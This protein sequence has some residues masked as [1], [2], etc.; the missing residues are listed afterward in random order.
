MENKR[1][2]EEQKIETDTYKKLSQKVKLHVNLEEYNLSHK[3]SNLTEC[4]LSILKYYNY[5]AQNLFFK[6]L[7]K[8]FDSVNKLE[9]LDNGFDIYFRS[10]GEMGKISR[11]FTKYF[12]CDEKRSKTL[13]GRDQLISKDKYRYFMSIHLINL[14]KGDKIAIK[15]EEFTIKAINNNTLIISSYPF[16]FKDLYSSFITITIMISVFLY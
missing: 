4:V 7:L 1:T 13:V 12:L 9:E 10:Y 16:I 2:E 15:G 3:Y 6:K 11:I 8:D 14:E 5:N